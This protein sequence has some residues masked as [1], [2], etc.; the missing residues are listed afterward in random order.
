MFV[1]DHEVEET[2]RNVRF[3]ANLY[4]YTYIL[5]IYFI[6]M[7]IWSFIVYYVTINRIMR[8]PPHNGRKQ[9]MSVEF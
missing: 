5:Y 8:K 3:I 4:I 7:Y 9:R 6:Y 1:R 2:Q